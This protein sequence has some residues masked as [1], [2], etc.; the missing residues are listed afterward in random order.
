MAVD[1]KATSASWGLDPPL[2]FCVM[3]VSKCDCDWVC[4][5]PH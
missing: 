5:C 3:P 2:D 4:S 1:Q